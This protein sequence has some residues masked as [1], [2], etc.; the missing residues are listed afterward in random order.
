MPGPAPTRPKKRIDL[1]SGTALG[2]LRTHCCL[3][4][5][6]PGFSGI[7]FAASSWNDD[8]RHQRTPESNATFTSVKDPALMTTSWGAAEG[9]GAP[10]RL[11]ARSSYVPA[12]SSSWNSPWSLLVASR[13][14]VPE[15][16]LMVIWA[17]RAMSGQGVDSMISG[18]PASTVTC[19]LMPEF[20]GPVAQETDVPARHAAMTADSKKRSRMLILQQRFYRD[21]SSSNLTNI[22][23]R[24][25]A[26]E[27]GTA[28]SSAVTQQ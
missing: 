3:S 26:S 9:I 15:R 13:T 11:A 20:A 22:R 5:G 2:P 19:P 25:P 28:T 7:A 16:S 10:E 24:T 8:L 21:T 23:P 17:G 27:F 14:V 12:G 4:R 1:P 18:H 6:L